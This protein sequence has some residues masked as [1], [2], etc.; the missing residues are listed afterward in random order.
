MPPFSK[1]NQLVRDLV[2][3]PGAAQN[4]ILPGQPSIPLEDLN[5][6]KRL[7]YDDLWSEDLDRIAPRL[8]IMTTPSSA[9]IM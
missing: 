7:L 8:W 2:P 1:A 6:T 5:R 9:N 4:E 3:Q